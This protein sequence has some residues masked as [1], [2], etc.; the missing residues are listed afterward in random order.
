[1]GLDAI[2]QNC[3]VN[4]KGPG[5]IFNGPQVVGYAADNYVKENEMG[6]CDGFEVSTSFGS[7]GCVVIEGNHCTIIND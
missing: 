1:M 4:N 5:S 2:Y 6:T 7:F 3:F